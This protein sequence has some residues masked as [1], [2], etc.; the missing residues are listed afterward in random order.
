MDLRTAP[1]PPFASA[2]TFCASGDVP[3]SSYFLR[4]VPTNSKVFCTAHDCAGKGDLNK[5]Y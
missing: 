2:H 1:P 3:E 4:T 5:G